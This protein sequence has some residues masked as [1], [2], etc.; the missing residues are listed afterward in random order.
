MQTSQPVP[1]PCLFLTVKALLKVD[2]ALES[3]GV[4]TLVVGPTST[5]VV[6]FYGVP[7]YV[8]EDE[9]EALEAGDET[10]G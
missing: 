4:G 9:K 6:T 10:D 1:T 2:Q 8:I 5:L 7:F 3:C